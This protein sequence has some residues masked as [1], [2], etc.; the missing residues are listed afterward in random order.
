MSYR[1]IQDVSQV[2]S[3][4][5]SWVPVTGKAG[6]NSLWGIAEKSWLH[7]GGIKLWFPCARRW[8]WIMRMWSMVTSM[9]FHSELNLPSQDHVFGLEVGP[10]VLVTSTGIASTYLPA[11]EDS[12]RTSYRGHH[13]WVLEETS[14]RCLP[15]V[16]V[17]PVLLP[18]FEDK[19]QNFEF[20]L[21]QQTRPF[22]SV[23]SAL[24][25]NHENRTVISNVAWSFARQFIRSAWSTWK[26]VDYKGVE[27][28][29]YPLPFNIAVGPFGICRLTCTT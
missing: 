13:W 14:L 25:D 24:S 9:E 17:T 7:S 26:P 6:E 27:F 10:L 15:S 2:T 28:E 8:F 1:N 5:Y 4:T 22:I 3:G 16:I 11:I 19:L 23:P 21:M 20:T 18:G 29:Y 12:L